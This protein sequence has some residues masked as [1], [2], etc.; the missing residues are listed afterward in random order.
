MAEL[1]GA[2]TSRELAKVLLAKY[3]LLIKDLSVKLNGKQYVRIAVRDTED[4]NKLLN[5]LKQE[6]R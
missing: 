1:T 3:D 5:A 4:N 6:M 2:V